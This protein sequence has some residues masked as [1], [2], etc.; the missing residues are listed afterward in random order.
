MVKRSLP[1]SGAYDLERSIFS[2]EKNVKIT[3]VNRYMP[4]YLWK[5][6]M[7]RMGLDPYNELLKLVAGRQ[8][9]DPDD[10]EV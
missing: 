5:D 10:V 4:V 9:N 2:L 3:Y 8:N 1:R 6:R 7:K